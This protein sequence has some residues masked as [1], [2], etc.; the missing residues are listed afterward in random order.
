MN[1]KTFNFDNMD[2]ELNKNEVD[3]WQFDLNNFIDNKDLLKEI[4]S[5][6]ERRR[7]NSFAF[8]RLG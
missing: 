7:V 1:K 8:C 4:L 2:M 6:D 5:Q 3:I